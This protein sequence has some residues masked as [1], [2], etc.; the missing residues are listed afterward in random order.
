MRAYRWKTCRSRD[1]LTFR[2]LEMWLSKAQ[3]RHAR[4]AANKAARRRRREQPLF[5][6]DDIGYI[7]LDAS[8]AA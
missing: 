6:D 2:V 8:E 1:G 3:R 5:S 7:V 4:Y